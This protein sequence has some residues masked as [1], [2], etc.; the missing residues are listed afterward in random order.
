MPYF[1]SGD[2]KLFYQDEGQGEPLLFLH[3]F[4]FDHRL[5]QPQ[6]DF[7]SS[8]YRTLILDSRGHGKSDAPE[9]GYSRDHRAEDTKLLLDELKI[10]KVHLVGL[11]MG[12]S[13]AIGFALNY[14]KRLKSLSLV[15][16]GA[17]GHSPGKKI[18]ILDE[19]A[20]TKGI[21][22]AKE[23]WLEWILVWFKKRDPE[24]GQLFE[25]MVND[26]SG[27]IWVDPMRGKYP[28][29]LDLENVHRIQ[30]PTLIIAGRY[31]K[32]FLELSEEL[33]QKIENSQLIVLEEAGHMLNLEYPDKF[34][35]ELLNFIESIE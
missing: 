9:T 16:T 11:S 22:A 12:G 15:S 3:G 32:T 7:F 27:A 10:D 26:F 19:I 13:T 29:T 5:W 25:T 28:R 20:Q 35:A 6:L 31:D 17:A 34:N 33:N 23:K 14:P 8:N 18:G 2:V 1:H 4:T 30:T 21:E 24:I